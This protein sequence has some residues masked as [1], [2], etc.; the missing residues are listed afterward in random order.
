VR[1]FVPEKAPNDRA[2]AD[3][4]EWYED[5]MTAWA[6]R[7]VGMARQLMPKTEIYLCTGGDGNPQLGADF[8][9]QAKSIAGQGAGIRITNEGSDYAHNFTVTREVATA[10]RL[11]GTFCGF[12]PAS[13]V[14][15]KGVVARIYNAIASGARQLHDYT[16]NMMANPK[17]LQS[18]RAF[19]TWLTPQKPKVSVALYLSRE[20]WELEPK[21]LAALYDVSRSL[22]DLT[23][24]SFVTSRSVQ[25]GALEGCR[26]LVLA[27]SPVLDPAAAKVIEQWVSKGGLL[28]AAARAGETVGG[29]LQD[30]N[31][32]RGALF[33]PGLAPAELLRQEI[34]GPP[35]PHWELAIGSRGD[36]GWL[37][38]QW[39]GPERGGEWRAI[40]NAQKRW[41]SGVAGV[42]LPTAAGAD[43]QLRISCFVPP[44]AIAKGLGEVR[45]NGHVVG[46][47]EKSGLLDLTLPLPVAV[48]EGT[49]PARLEIVTGTWKPSDHQQ[50]DT[51]VLGLAVRAVEL[52]RAGAEGTPAGRAVLRLSLDRDR[53]AQ[54]IRP[55]GRGWTVML[56]SAGDS[57]AALANV[58]APLL[59]DTGTYFPGLEPIAPADGRMDG[60]YATRVDDKW[61]WL[62]AKEGTIK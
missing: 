2:R 25:D 9:A 43:Y 11:Y 22:R 33:Q 61:I 26:A 23:D 46:K 45:V 12:E 40:P 42:Y 57:P 3:M 4:V 10:T 29:R 14:N 7:W 58:L 52:I 8:T 47:I 13:Q 16:P 36:D 31:A 27:E 20:T 32:W 15:E 59:T 49:S 1:P 38:G 28:I 41:T 21:R 48:L 62:D 53:V 18:F 56:T 51:R 44:Y 34:A 54:A 17:A 6:A 60:R 30:D 39:H 24:H 5:S 19:A 55:V 37:F 35:P 50:G